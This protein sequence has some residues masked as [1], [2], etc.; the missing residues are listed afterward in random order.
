[1]RSSETGR[2]WKACCYVGRVV[3]ISETQVCSKTVLFI[4]FQPQVANS[5]QTHSQL[6]FLRWWRLRM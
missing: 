1:M 4:E 6:K 3:S 2:Q 5:S